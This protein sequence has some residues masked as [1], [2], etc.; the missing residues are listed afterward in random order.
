MK[1]SINKIHT[2]QL[3]KFHNDKICND[4]STNI[5][6]NME[7]DVNVPKI[8]YAYSIYKSKFI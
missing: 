4:F 3:I 2:E 6:S 1:T 5:N 7:K 8:D